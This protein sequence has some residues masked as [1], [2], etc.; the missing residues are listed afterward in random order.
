MPTCDNYVSYE[1][2]KLNLSMLNN[3]EIGF[4]RAVLLNVHYYRYYLFYIP[5]ILRVCYLLDW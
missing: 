5:T 1:N 4:W 2:L 3:R